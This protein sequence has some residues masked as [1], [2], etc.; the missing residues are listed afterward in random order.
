MNKKFVI[1]PDTT[2]DLSEALQKEYEIDV[3]KGHFTTPDGKE[4]DSIANWSEA[5]RDD[6]Y[7]NLKRCKNQ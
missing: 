4:H 5:D 7:K 6:F 2:C 3:I 1:M